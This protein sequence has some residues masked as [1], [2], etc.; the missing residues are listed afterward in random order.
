MVLSVV[1]TRTSS[2]FP[3]KKYPE[4][5]AVP[6]LR[7]PDISVR[8]V[9]EVSVNEFERAEPLIYHVHV[10]DPLLTSLIL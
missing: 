1:E 2:I 5:V 3:L 6:I 7:V 8:S 9:S 10:V 4:L